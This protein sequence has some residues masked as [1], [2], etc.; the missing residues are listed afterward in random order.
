METNEYKRLAGLGYSDAEIQ[1]IARYHALT[2]AKTDP[3]AG[4]AIC[5]HVNTLLNDTILTFSQWDGSDLYAADQYGRMCVIPGSWWN[6]AY[7]IRGVVQQKR[8]GRRY[9]FLCNGQ[10]GVNAAQVAY[11]GED[12]R[13][14]FLAFAGVS[15]AFNAVF[16]KSRQLV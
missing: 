3:A 4:I 5:N 12:V 2:A 10:A 6:D 8:R 14:P 15:A 9:T 11:F 7:I 13:L 1:S 16:G